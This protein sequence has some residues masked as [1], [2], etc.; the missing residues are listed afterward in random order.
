[1]QRTGYS[2]NVFS[3]AIKGL[4]GEKLIEPVRNR[5]KHGEFGA[6]EYL[7][8]SPKD[9]T[10][11]IPKQNLMYGNGLPY[12]TFPICVVTEHTANWSLA[13]MSSSELKLYTSI[14]YLANRN[15]DNE[16]TATAGELR[17]LSGLAPATFRRALDQLECCGLVWVTP[18]PKAYH[19]QLCDPYTG[20]PIHE[21][22]GFDE[23]DPANYFTKGDKGQSK[24]LNLNTGNPEQVEKLIRSCVPEEPIVQG[25][26]DLTIRCPF[27][28]D[29]TPSC[30]VSPR[31]NGC[32]HCFGCGKS[33]SL[34][35][36]IMQL[37]SITKGEAIQQTAT[38]MGMEIEFHQ[39][40]EK[41]LAI[42]SYRNDKGKL[43]KQILRYPDENGEK[44]FRQ[45]RPAKG[46]WAWN[47]S[48]LPPMLFNV[49]LLQ[50][51]DV[52]GITEGEKDAQK[53]TA[54]GLND[55]CLIGTTSGG[56]ESWDASLAKLL[57]WKRVVLMPDADEAGANYAADVKASLE[58]EGIEYRVVSFEDVGAKDVTE[59]LEGGH[60]VEELAQRIGT[61]WVNI[62][63]SQ[64]PE[65]EF[66]PE[67]EFAQQDI[68]I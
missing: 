3:K 15:R 29:S 49:E 37:Q 67:T 5:K 32:F 36:L 38:A 13:N 26:G 39:P 1:M 14:L 11:L 44:V 16:F 21:L 10:P 51:A 53:I 52:V 59:F 9:G 31:K 46:E 58:A 50:F 34:T 30:S 42:Y 68:A 47:T 2:K 24:R 6:T 20:Q 45:R 4:Q 8:C 56:A 17:K 48:G 65:R 22:D 60:T 63:E 61:D 55:G 19:I 64:H 28:S 66:Q 43:L 62:P 25:N 18:R 40:D 33:G 54:L 23:N 7:L 27:H 12:F 41:A 35:D 57:H